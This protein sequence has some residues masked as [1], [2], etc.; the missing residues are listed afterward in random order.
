MCQSNIYSSSYLA[1]SQC[2][3]RSLLS[4]AM[5][6]IFLSLLF[7]GLT[8]ADLLQN[9]DF[10]SPPANLTGNSTSPF[11]LLSQNNTVPGWTFEGTVQYVTAGQNISL[12]G[13]GHAIQLCQDGKIN[14]TFIANGAITDYVLT[15]T[16]AAG[17]RNCSNNADV[18]ISVPDSTK[19]FSL[20]Q[21]YGKETWESYGHFLGSWGEEEPVNLVFQS[22]TAESNPNSTCWPVIDSLLLKSVGTLPDANDNLLPNGGFETGPDFLSNSTEGILLDE[23]PS[24]VQSPLRPWSVLG[25]VKYIDSKHF[26]VP[27]G[28]T[29]IEI[30]S[31]V[32]AG[33]QTAVI[34]K[35]GS[36]YNLEFTLGDAND[37]CVGDFIVGAQAGSTTK[38]FSLAS[39]GTGSAKKFSVAFMAN[40]STTPIS[41]LS[42]T[43]SQTR[44]GVH[45]GPVVDDVVL[46]ASYGLKL[47]M[48]L[49]VLISLFIVG[50][51]L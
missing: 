35:E 1:Q 4:V 12:P 11:M 33:I 22:Q 38:N 21:H 24:A 8:S 26:F 42:Y 39:N 3:G 49:K 28:N 34:L 27:Q 18:V 17:G 48:Q 7:M 23:N 41:F 32:S 9:P 29:A 13:N 40:P 43:T 20:K 19:V 6:T 37:T 44:D 15:L 14:Q 50:A 5:K 25:S 46:R 36:K 51:I 45:C 47:E 16:V 31:G 10:E 2:Y 30:V